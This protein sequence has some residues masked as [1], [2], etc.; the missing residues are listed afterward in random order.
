MQYAPVSTTGSDRSRQLRCARSPF[1]FET[2]SA[3]TSAEL[4]PGVQ[5]FSGIHSSHHVALES[6]GMNESLRQPIRNRLTDRV[7][8]HLDTGKAAETR[9]DFCQVRDLGVAVLYHSRGSFGVYLTVTSRS[10]SPDLTD[11]HICRRDPVNDPPGISPYYELAKT[12]ELITK[13]QADFGVGFENKELLEHPR[14]CRGSYAPEVIDGGSCEDY[15]RLVFINRPPP[16]APSPRQAGCLPQSW[17][18]RA[19]SSSRKSP[20]APSTSSKGTRSPESVATRERTSARSRRSAR[21]CSRASIRSIPIIAAT[22]SPC[23]S[24]MMS[25]SD[26]AATRPDTPRRVASVILKRRSTVGT[27]QL[28]RFLYSSAMVVPTKTKARGLEPRRRAPVAEY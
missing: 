6:S 4:R 12:C 16:G 7:G 10:H 28:Y 21:A 17:S 24:R 15:A 5:R 2:T 22:G 26:T 14:Y 9:D 1:K 3:S 25:A 20:K 11:L 19:S 8:K 18:G 27:G 23:R 13:G